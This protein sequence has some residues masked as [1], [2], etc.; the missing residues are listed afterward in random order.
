M[1][2]SAWRSRCV[3][4]TRAMRTWV[5]PCSPKPMPG[6]T[7]TRAFSSS[8]LLNPTLPRCA[9][10]SG[11]G[12][13]ANIEPSGLGTIQP[14]ACSPRISTSRRSRYSSR[15]SVTQS[16]GPFSAAV[17]AIWIGAKAP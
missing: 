6:A 4:S 7:A 9:K 2:R 11:I 10:R 12:A 8:S 3:F 14:A 13:Q 1:L 5:S 15:I 16:C 17:A